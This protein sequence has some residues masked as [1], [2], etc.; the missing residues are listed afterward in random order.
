MSDQYLGE[1][2][3]LHY[4]VVFRSKYFFALFAFAATYI[5]L[6]SAAVSKTI[7]HARIEALFQLLEVSATGSDVPPT[8]L[9]GEQSLNVSKAP[10]PAPA[11]SPIVGDGKPVSSGIPSVPFPQDAPDGKNCPVGMKQFDGV[12]QDIVNEVNGYEENIVALS[13]SYDK[14]DGEALEI[15]VSGATSCSEEIRRRYFNFLESAS[16]MKIPESIGPVENLQFCAQREVTELDKRIEAIGQ[17]ANRAEQ[18]KRNALSNVMKSVSRLDGE[19]TGIVQQ[20]V[21][22]EQKRLRLVIGV[23]DFESQ[24]AVFEGI[25]FGYD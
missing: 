12:F 13:A 8:T 1:S 5:C 19:M 7:D 23:Q 14:L 18:L 25:T 21:N 4:K 6:P 17:D 15:A 2:F 20:L 24:C 10:V 11:P 3:L 22:L 9:D 16:A